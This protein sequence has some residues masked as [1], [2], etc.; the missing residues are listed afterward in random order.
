MKR[1]WM[2][3]LAMG[4]VC[5]CAGSNPDVETDPVPR[6]QSIPGAESKAGSEPQMKNE[7][8]PETASTAAKFGIPPG[9]LP[10][11]GQCRVWIPGEPPGKQK[12]KY[13]SG[14]C[15]TVSRQVPP[16]AWLV[17]RPGD[18]KKEV[19]VREYG[20]GSQVTWVRVFDIAT[21]ALLRELDP[22][23]GR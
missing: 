14:E 1:L 13:A 22:D 6:T 23:D 5:A 20:S 4:G 21:G 17:Y 2:V 9:H 3:A 16:G 10:P 11:P 7:D 12:K 8:V 18:D 15:D 19:V